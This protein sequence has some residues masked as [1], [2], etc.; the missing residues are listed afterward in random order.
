MLHHT[1]LIPL[2]DFFRNPEKSGYQLSPSGTF[3]SWLAPY[4]HRMNIYVQDRRDGRILRITSEKERD[5]PAHFWKSDNCIMYVKDFGGDENFHIVSVNINGERLRDLT[6]FPQVR[7]QIIDPLED[8]DDIMLIGLNKRNPEVFDAYRL[9]IHTGE[10]ELVAENPGT[11][12]GWMTDHTGTLRIAIATDGVNTTIL[13]RISENSEFQPVITTNFRESITPLLFTFDNQH[14]YAASNIGRDKSAIVV[15]DLLTGKERDVL[16]EHDEVDVSGLSYSRKRKVLTAISFTT[17]KRERVFLDKLAKNLYQRAAARLAGY[18]VVVADMNRDEDIMLIRTYSDRSLGAYYLFD[19]KKDKLSKLSD[20]SPWLN[21]KD[22]CEMKP[23][24]YQ[25]RDGLTIHGYLTLPKLPRH[26]PAR[27]LPVVVHPHGGPWVRDTWGYNPE[28]QFLANRGYAV[29]Q[30]NYRGSTGYGRAFWEK[31]FKQW[32]RAMQHDITD[33][34]RWLIAEG[35][36]DPKRIGIYGGSYGGYAVLAGLAFTP[37]LY[38]CGVDYVG[39]SNLFTFLNTIPPYWKPYLSMMY[40]MVG[41]PEKDKELLYEASPVFHVDNIQAPLL[42]AQG[43]ND[44][45]V[46]INESNQIVE[47]LRKRG[48]DVP[49]I[50]KDNEGHGFRNEE[51]RFEFYEAMEA[52]LAQ[53]LGSLDDDAR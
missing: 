48:I 52:F 39:V 44:P 15:F 46:N 49:Y 51:N 25:S 47:A 42:V 36:A 10:L 5:I 16:F 34:V 17:W 37:E 53:H 43:A 29:L 50:V 3:L 28:V 4:E 7:A 23:I 31:G 14:I 2:R 21:E 30:M 12:T 8:F 13:H 27:N 40:E 32:G 45:R 19:T 22:L 6:P 9:H 38:A 20:V 11:I 35:I 41:H 24:R 33:G 18:E 26:R 1:R